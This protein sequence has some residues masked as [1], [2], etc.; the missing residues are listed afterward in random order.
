MIASRILTFAYFRNRRCVATER[1]LANSAGRSG[2]KL[3]ESGLISRVVFHTGP[4]P[5]AEVFMTA[6]RLDYEAI[7]H[8]TRDIP[9]PDRRQE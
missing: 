1:G 2:K 5:D 3:Y 8:A 9:D 7:F 4:W 6:S